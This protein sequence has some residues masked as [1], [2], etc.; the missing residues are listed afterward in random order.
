MEPSKANEALNFIIDRFGRRVNLI[1]RQ[2]VSRGI[3]FDT[4]N[5]GDGLLLGQLQALNEGYSIFN[6]LAFAEGI[7][8]LVAYVELCRCAGQRGFG[9]C[10][11][12]SRDKPGSTSP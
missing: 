6:T 11:R 7:H 8:P 5:P 3:S 10:V 9:G 2:I 1:S 12:C 4:H